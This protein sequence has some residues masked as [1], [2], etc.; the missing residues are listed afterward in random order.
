MVDGERGQHRISDS[1]KFLQ[2][3]TGAPGTLGLCARSAAMK[4]PKI[5]G[6]AEIVSDRN[7]RT[8]WLPSWRLMARRYYLLG[9]ALRLVLFLSSTWGRADRHTPHDSN[10]VWGVLFCT[11]DPLDGNSSCDKIF[12]VVLLKMPA[13]QE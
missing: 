4:S 5:V 6:A 3:Q 8:G 1:G 11:L 2:T 9:V 12:K 7:S 10:R 13:W